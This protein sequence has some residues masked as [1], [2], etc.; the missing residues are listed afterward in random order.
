MIEGVVQGSSYPTMS[1]RVNSAIHLLSA[2][3]WTLG[4][5]LGVLFGPYPFCSTLGFRVWVSAG[6]GL[7]VADLLTGVKQWRSPAAG[8]VLSTVLHLVVTTL[9]VSL[10]TF[11]YLQAQPKSF[12]VWFRAG[13]YSFVAALALVRLA[14]GTTLLLGNEDTH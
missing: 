12:L 8:R 13:D 10:I 9:I 14:I 3:Y 5:A 6:I 11:E 2:L 7:I 4:T 1:H